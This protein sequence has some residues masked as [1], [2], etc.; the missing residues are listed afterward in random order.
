MATIQAVTGPIDTGKLGR[1]LM[2][3]H[4]IT[5]SPGVIENWP[6]L[7]DRET[8]KQQAIVK[9]QDVQRRGIDTL[10]DLTTV[11]L[12]RDVAFVREIAAGAGVNVIVA[13]GIWWQPQRYFHSRE[14]DAIA[15]LFV[16]DIERGTA[17]TNIR[18]GIIKCATDTEGATP[19]IEKILRASARAHRRTG[20]PISTHTYAAGE[21]GTV[22]QDIFASEGVD[23]SRVIIGH[24][25]DSEDL[26]YLKRLMDRGSSIGMDRFGIDRLLPTDRRVATIAALCK[27]G[28]AGKMVLSHDASCFSD[29]RDAET[30]RRQWP[31]WHYNHIPDDVLPALR[32]QG[33]SEAQIS[34]ML[35][36]NPRR[37]FE[38]Q[39]AY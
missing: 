30:V 39:G 33:V 25:G 34:Q 9:L 2:H 7:W 31:N 27:E 21:M 17:G 4:I 35:V 19:P 15:D 22:Q 10:V 18:C 13:T 24:S 16:Q 12:G 1:V 8:V 29:A 5:L 6:G 36:D 37:I 3:E 28:Y 23:L 32:A 38:Q 14:V 20:V 11:D 26:G